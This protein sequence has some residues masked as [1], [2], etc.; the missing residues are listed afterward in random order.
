MVFAFN[1]LVLSING[2]GQAY[3]CR[4]VLGSM[5]YM[6][7]LSMARSIP[8]IVVL[9][10]GAAPICIGKQGKKRAI[11]VGCALQI[12]SCVIMWIAPLS[13]TALTIGNILKGCFQGLVNTVLFAT[14]A[15][16]SDYVD[17]KNNV[18]I[19]GITNIITSFGMKVG[20]GFGSAVLGYVL[21]WGNYNPA[22]IPTGMP[23]E[24]IL[25]EKIAY[26]VVPGICLLVVLLIDVDKSCPNCALPGIREETDGAKHERVQTE[27][28]VR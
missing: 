23:A 8:V 14:I 18:S 5:R 15:D 2:G 6:S 19:S 20:V 27:F 1:W 3:Y 4:D 13:V 10:I 7:T 25:A 17:L 28:P 26:I 12:L 24:T 21:S 22:N 16:V 9:L 11:V